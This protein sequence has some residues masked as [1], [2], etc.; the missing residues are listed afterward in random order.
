MVWFWFYG[1][2]RHFLQYFSYIVA[3]SCIDGENRRKP[4][5]MSI[6]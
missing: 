1:V 6:T 2:K 3:A 4:L 5:T